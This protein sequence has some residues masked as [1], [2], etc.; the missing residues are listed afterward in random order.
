MAV[1]SIRIANKNN[2]APEAP[3][4][5]SKHYAPKRKYFSIKSLRSIKKYDKIKI[6]VICF[7]RNFTKATHNRN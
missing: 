4:M 6:G 3:G 7:T 5:L 2:Q 1:G